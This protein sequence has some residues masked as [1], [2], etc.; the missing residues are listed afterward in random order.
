MMSFLLNKNFSGQTSR[1]NDQESPIDCDE[2]DVASS[3]TNR[4]NNTTLDGLDT[5]ILES[6]DDNTN[7]PCKTKT[8]A[9]TQTALRG[10]SLMEMIQ[11]STNSS[12]NKDDSEAGNCH[13]AE[14]S[15]GA[16]GSSKVVEQG[17][18]FIKCVIL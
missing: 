9:E 12:S 8:N 15:S 11:C 5:N 6:L 10:V 18:I 14:A 13:N 1:F 2:G 3:S 16:P 17:L 7:Q 4:I